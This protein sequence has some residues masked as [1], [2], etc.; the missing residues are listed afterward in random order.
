MK[1]KIWDWLS[2]RLNEFNWGQFVISKGQ[3]VFTLLIFLKVYKVSIYITLILAICVL[4][5]TWIIGV[6]FNKNNPDA[7]IK[8]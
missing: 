2:K 3:F 4:I 8:N 5:F 6:V 1:D 7:D